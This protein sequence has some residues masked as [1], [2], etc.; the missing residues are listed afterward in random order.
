[1]NSV[2]LEVEPPKMCYSNG[3]I[4]MCK[5]KKNSLVGEI[6]KICENIRYL[7]PVVTHCVIY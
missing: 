5:E 4:N 2:Q 1:M 7:K 3:D 6:Y